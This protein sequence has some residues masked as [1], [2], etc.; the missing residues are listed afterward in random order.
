MLGSQLKEEVFP[1]DSGITVRKANARGG[2]G[3]KAGEE[4]QGVENTK[5]AEAKKAV[6]VFRDGQVVIL[7]DG[8]EFNVLGAELK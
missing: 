6:K 3:L 7:R 4:P 2:F 8:R 5:S 1:E